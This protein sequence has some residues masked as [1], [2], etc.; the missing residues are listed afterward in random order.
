MS[1]RRTAKVAEA[2]RQVVSTAILF[3]LRDPRVK[4]VTILGVEVPEDLRTAKI[5]ISIMGDEKTAKLTLKGLDSAKGW[6]QSKIAD[7]LKLRYTPLVTFAVDHGIQNVQKVSEILEQL[8]KER[9]GEPEVSDDYDLD[10]DELDD[11]DLLDSSDAAFEE[12]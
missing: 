10:D 12:E 11:E 1:T 7:E 9:Q 5:K 2:I 4:N 6:L 8:K 3:E